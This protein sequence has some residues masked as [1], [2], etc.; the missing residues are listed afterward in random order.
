MT[1]QMESRPPGSY[2]QS[3]YEGQKLESSLTPLKPDNS[4]EEPPTQRVWAGTR[5]GSIGKCLDMGKEDNKTSN[6]AKEEHETM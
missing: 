3:S 5:T 2:R 6:A 1:S 4:C